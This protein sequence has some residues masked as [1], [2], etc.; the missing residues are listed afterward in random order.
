MCIRDRQEELG[1][2]P[3]SPRWA[4]AVKFPPQQEVTVVEGIEVNVGRTG[5]LTP[6]A[7]LRPVRVGGVTV[8][9]ASLHNQD[10]LERKDIRIGDYIVIQRAGDVIPQ[11]VRVRIDRRREA[12]AEGRSLVRARLPE[13]CP[14]CDAKTVRLAGESVT[15]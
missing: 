6:V 8:S 12:L 9:N 15:R 3:R 5:A 14:V 2:L 13:R 4:I 10:E 7:R 11:V 1:N